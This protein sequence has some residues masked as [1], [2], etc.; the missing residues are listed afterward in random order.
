[1]EIIHQVLENLRDT[2]DLKNKYLD[3]DDLWAGILAATTFFILS[4]YH[5]M[6]RAMPGQMVFVR[7]MILNTQAI[8]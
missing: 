5:T 1:M 2:F 8:N 3:E 4:T 6:L 7:D